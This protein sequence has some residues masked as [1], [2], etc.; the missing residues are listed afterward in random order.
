MIPKIKIKK[1]RYINFSSDAIYEQNY[2]YFSIN[3]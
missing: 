1:E 3:N 2:D